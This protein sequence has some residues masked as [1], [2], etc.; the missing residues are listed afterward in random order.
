MKEAMTKVID[1]L[2]REDFYGAFQKLLERY[3]KCNAAV[4]DYFE[5]DESFMCVLLIKVP[6]RK[7]S[8]NVFNDPL[9]TIRIFCIA[10]LFLLRLRTFWTIYVHIS[11]LK[12]FP[13]PITLAKS[14][15]AVEHTDSITVKG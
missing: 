13:L 15:G 5:G 4:G 1:T 2:T 6:I 8:G 14:A 11:G 7:K 9:T 12:G 3:N 10:F